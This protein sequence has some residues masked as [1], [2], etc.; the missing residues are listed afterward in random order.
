MPLCSNDK[1]FLSP[2]VTMMYTQILEAKKS[3]TLMRT[4]LLRQV[5]FYL[6]FQLSVHIHSQKKKYKNECSHQYLQE[7]V[8]AVGDKPLLNW[9]AS[10]LNRLAGVATIWTDVSTCG[11]W[12]LKTSLMPLHFPLC[13]SMWPSMFKLSFTSASP[14]PSVGRAVGC[15]MLFFLLYF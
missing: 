5:K 9:T 13:Q 8:P 10:V 2:K 14:W 1:N 15:G 7:I 11:S 3:Q 6:I 4:C 12:G